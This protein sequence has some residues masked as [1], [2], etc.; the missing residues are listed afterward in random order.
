MAGRGEILAAVLAMAGH[1]I[2]V[3]GFPLPATSLATNSPVVQKT[4]SVCDCG[5]G[6]GADCCCGCGGKQSAD[7]EPAT[8]PSEEDGWHWASGLQVQKCRGIGP[9]A[10][11]ELLPAVPAVR[12]I[13]HL[14]GGPANGTLALKAATAVMRPAVPPTPPPRLG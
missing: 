11:A 9:S 5:C 3:I 4:E 7:P 8:S 10:I 14:F 12:Q 6:R 1:A 13:N 2:G